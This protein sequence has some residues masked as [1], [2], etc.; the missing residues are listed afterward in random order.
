[1]TQK[2][3]FSFYLSQGNLIEKVFLLIVFIRNDCIIIPD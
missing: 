3:G 2:N 1:M